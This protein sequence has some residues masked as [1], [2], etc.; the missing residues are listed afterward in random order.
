M[1]KATTVLIINASVDTEGHIKHGN[2]RIN[3]MYNKNTENTQG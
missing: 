2:D 3:I 1:K